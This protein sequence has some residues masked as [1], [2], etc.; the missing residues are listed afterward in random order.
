MNSFIFLVASLIFQILLDANTALGQSI[1]LLDDVVVSWSNTQFDTTFTV[2][3]TLG[4]DIDVEDCWVGVAF[5]N[6]PQMV[7]SN[8]FITSLN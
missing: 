7:T 2:V 8:L 4:A 3:S 6:L 1:T 5:N